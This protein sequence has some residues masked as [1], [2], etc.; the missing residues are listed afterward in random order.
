ME[1][2]QYSIFTNLI[3]TID[4]RILVVA[5]ELLGAQVRANRASLELWCVS[6]KKIARSPVF[7][8]MVVA[9]LD[10]IA[11]LPLPTG[12]FDIIMVPDVANELVEMS[13]M[14]A[15]L[16]S[17]LSRRGRLLLGISNAAYWGNL[18][19]LTTDL[20][21]EPYAS[22]PRQ[23]L[24][25]DMV[26]R[27]LALSEFRV[28]TVH[29]V[30]DP[31]V[32]PPFDQLN[33]DAAVGLTVSYAVVEAELA[34]QVPSEGA[35]SLGDGALS[36]ASVI[37][38]TYNSMETIEACVESVLRTLREEDELIVV[39]N[40]SRDETVARVA[41]R[42]RGQKRARLIQNSENVGF[43]AGCNI[44]IRDSRCRHVCLLNP[45]TVVWSGWLEKFESLLADP[46]V[47]MVGPVSDRIGGD[48]FVGHYIPPGTPV[49]D[50][51]E[52]ERFCR[53]ELAGRLKVTKL[54]IGMC[55]M[56]R[57]E[58]LDRLGVLDERMFLGS[59]DLEI[60]WRLRTH[61]LKLLV[62]QEAF[63][64]HAGGV[65]FASEPSERVRQLLFDSTEALLDKVRSHYGWLPCDED[66]WGIRITHVG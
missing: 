59:E 14:L 32:P 7:D 42:L 53:T 62:A 9:T 61:G 66:L 60:S 49:M 50:L 38:L 44:G 35:E 1:A 64:H 57:R 55:V 37:V 20:S 10:A 36:G 13:A 27:R 65:S 8:R 58:T 2:P 5:D 40:A 39:D 26:R 21:R 23:M 25:P 24:T 18:A 51:D 48:Q 54:L 30:A 3:R 41:D 34:A 31:E 16:R 15:N 12:H 28:R 19:T 22:V 52:L 43:A 33:Q 11:P 56:L 17:H 63:V 45:D 29:E 6:G 4:T 47:G 46:G